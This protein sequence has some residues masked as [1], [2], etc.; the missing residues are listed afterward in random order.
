[1]TT[2]SDVMSYQQFLAQIKP[3]MLDANG[4]FKGPTAG[5]NY[6]MEGLTPQ[7]FYD[8]L[9]SRYQNQVSDATGG[10]EG[11]G[12]VKP[13]TPDAV[14]KA[15]DPSWQPGAST[16]KDG[17]L[18]DAWDFLTS[19]EVLQGIAM[20]IAGGTAFGPDT[21]GD[22]GGGLDF[23]EVTPPE[24]LPDVPPEVPPDV[25]EI[26]PE[27]PPPTT[28]DVPDA[29]AGT[30]PETPPPTSTMGQTFGP[31]SDLQNSPL[32]NFADLVKNHF[33]D[34]SGAI[35]W[36]NVIKGGAAALAAV[37]AYQQAKDASSGS[38]GSNT[39]GYS[40]T[41]PTYSASRAAVPVPDDYKPGSGGIRYLTDVAYNGSGADGAA[42][43]QAQV[44]NQQSGLA[45]QNQVN[46]NAQNAK[47]AAAKA[48]YLQTHGV[49]TG[50]SGGGGDVPPGGPDPNLTNP[51]TGLPYLTPGPGSP[52]GPN[53]PDPN[54]TGP[55]GYAIPSPGN[56][57]GPQPD[58]NLT[59]PGGYAIPSPAN[60]GGQPGTPGGN[61]MPGSP[62]TGGTGAAGMY[63]GGNYVTKAQLQQA[64]ASG[65]NPVQY[66]QQHGITDSSQIH[67]LVTQAE[68]I[69]GNYKTGDAALQQYF[70]QYQQYNPNG[71][72]AKDYA[73]WK[74]DQPADVLN[75]MVN[76][77][78]TGSTAT[79]QSDFAPGGIYGPGSVYYGQAGY[80]NGQ[81]PRGMGTLGGGWDTPGA[82]NG[83]TSQL[84]ADQ[85]KA[86]MDAAAAGQPAPNFGGG[87]APVSAAQIQSFYAQ[88]KND[89]AAIQ[90]AMTQYHVTPQQAAAAT[91]QS[92][93]TFQPAAQPGVSSADIMNFYNAHKNDPAA[94]Q[95]AM[96]QYKI[97]PQQAAAATGQSESV[98]T[99]Q[100]AL[101]SQ[102]Q[103]GSGGSGA[104]PPQPAAQPSIS[105]SDINNFYQAHQGD[106]AAIKA[107][108]QQYNVTADQAAA[109]TGQSASNFQF[110]RGGLAGLASARVGGHYLRGNTDGMADQIPAMI[111]SKQPAALAHGEFVWPA[112]VVSDLGNGNSDAGAQVLHQAMDRIRTARHGTKAQGKR[113]DPHAFVPGGLQHAYAVGGAVRHFDNGG[114]ATLYPAPP[115]PPQGGGGGSGGGDSAPPVNLSPAM[116]Q[117][118]AG[119]ASSTSSTLSNWVAP[120]VTDMLGKGQ[121]LADQ[122][123]QQYPGQLTA[124]ASGLQNQGFDAASN[125]STPS[126]IGGAANSALSASNAAG[127]TNYQP[128]TFTA[129]DFT[130]PGVAQQFMSPYEDNVIQQQQR[131]AQRA[132]DVAT[133]YRQ[134]DQTK[135][136]GFGGSRAAIMD[137]E[138][139][140]NLALQKGDIATTGLQAAY[141]A[142]QN[143]FN[144]QQTNQLNNNQATEASRQFGAN[145][146]LQGLNTQINGA[147]TAGNLGVAQNN[148][149]TQNINTQ[150]G[151]G[152]V[153]QGITQAGLTADQNAFNQERQNPYNML[154]FQQSL[155]QGLPISTQS[156]NYPTNP[157]SAAA[158]AATGISSLINTFTGP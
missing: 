120:Y 33:V 153:Q 154:T 86:V 43:Q 42:N 66:L 60:P 44:A 76:G 102:I 77:N 137:S 5:V 149:N 100:G 89:P 22:V 52:G 59:G 34:A 61:G 28:P 99:P 116:P 53:G 117:G 58:P 85:Q 50:G 138:A 64:F 84:T 134:G 104:A 17:V 51:A 131:D 10:G 81:G 79:A 156:Y 124:D 91:G 70:Q 21:L 96:S 55:G 48:L 90:Q 13:P 80:A 135:Q 45:A 146:G 39:G 142:G 122:P 94:I 129:G 105:A 23:P 32:T 7:Q 119:G 46:V 63:I 24:T 36:A 155:L 133:T 35:N 114:A 4:T 82:A 47:A 16:M 56:P 75:A 109:A 68:G 152:G 83:S 144:T 1:M 108:M 67:D 2:N 101:Q 158:N 78:Y 19:H 88:H 92:A 141:S 57:H 12:F 29:P 132:A 139:A 110:A 72:W 151:A 106:Q 41:V 40:G 115:A 157:I 150:L 140:R 38:N 121:A 93:S 31:P 145:L 143:Q 37:T 73:G 97:T 125:L 3:A 107:A 148:A 27:T 30:P 87:S 9:I 15:L 130:Q 11:G 136:G 111:D 95:Q 123:Y 103:P 49:G 128:N 54:L 127:N 113:I 112:D 126:V 25:P 98:F 18:G 147:S 62:N 26:P 74:A 65:V 20:V 118:G 71:K 14:N 6:A 8:T 69:A